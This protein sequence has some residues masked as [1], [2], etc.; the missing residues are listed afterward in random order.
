MIIEALPDG[1]L[2][3]RQLTDLAV[4]VVRSSMFVAGGVDKNGN[5]HHHLSVFRP[6]EI[7]VVLPG[8]HKN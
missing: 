2:D 1:V 4:R 3:A 5:P 6:N 8:D 7:E